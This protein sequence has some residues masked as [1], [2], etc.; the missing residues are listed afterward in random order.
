MPP[1]TAQ[2]SRMVVVCKIVD[3]TG[4]A[5]VGDVSGG[6]VMWRKGLRGVA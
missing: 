2:L 3:G 6:V 1:P 4:R 5:E